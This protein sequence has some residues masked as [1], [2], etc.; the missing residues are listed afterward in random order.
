MGSREDDG[1]WDVKYAEAS[2]HEHGDEDMYWDAMEGEWYC[3]YC[4]ID[5]ELTETGNHG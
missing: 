5:D 2:C 4:F 3:G 1:W